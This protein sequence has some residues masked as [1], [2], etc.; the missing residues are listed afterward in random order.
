MSTLWVHARFIPQYLNQRP[1]KQNR[2][3]TWGSQHSPLCKRNDKINDLWSWRETV[4]GSPKTRAHGQQCHANSMK[5][6][7]IQE[8]VGMNKAV[9]ERTYLGL[10]Y[11]ISIL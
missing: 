10:S 5:S 4:G 6:A 11:D 9:F 3:G 1:T 7:A 8:S 2:F